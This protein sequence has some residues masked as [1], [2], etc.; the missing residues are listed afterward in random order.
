MIF[1]I[2]RSRARLNTAHTAGEPSQPKTPVNMIRVTKLEMRKANSL[3]LA[4]ENMN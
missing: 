3:A 1:E 4:A 2:R